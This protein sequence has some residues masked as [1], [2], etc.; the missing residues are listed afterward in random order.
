MNV[1]RFIVIVL[2]SVGI[3]ELPDAADFGD[4]GSHTLGN[5]AR[6][7]G[8]LNLPNLEKMGLANIALL[9]GMKPQEQPTAV[10]GKMAEVSAGKDTTIGHWE[11]MGV[12]SKRPFPTYPTGF[13]PDI[14]GRFEGM[15]GMTTLGNYPASGTVII[16]ELYEMCQTAR[17]ILTGEHEVARVIARPFI[18]EPGSFTRTANRH[19][20]SVSPPEPTLLDHLKEAGMMT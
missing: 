7:T 20:F 16:E 18:G 9:P 4:V 15:I 8:G 5:I 19:D 3:G 12:L 10:Y 6:V 11:L 17:E 13:P 14:I 1:N 2:D